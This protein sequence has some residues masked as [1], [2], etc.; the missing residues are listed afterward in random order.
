MTPRSAM[1]ELALD[2]IERHSLARHLDGVRVHAAG[3]ER[4]DASHSPWGSTDSAPGS[5]SEFGAV[6]RR[7]EDRP[8]GRSPNQHLPPLRL[9]ADRDGWRHSRLTDDAR[10]REHLGAQR[11][12]DVRARGAPVL[13]E[14]KPVVFV[15]S[16]PTSCLL[17]PLF[18]YTLTSR[19]V[20]Q[21]GGPEFET[22]PWKPNL[23]CWIVIVLGNLVVAAAGATRA[24]APTSAASALTIRNRNFIP[25]SSFCCFAVP[26]CAGFIVRHKVS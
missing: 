7:P 18:R 24:R 5:R 2:H 4:I 1:A 21:A 17:E 23:S 9:L 25:P 13:T 15:R 6:D 10:S 22:T 14:Q 20:W 12:A 16:Q 3:A 8:E 11:A 19:F 26:C